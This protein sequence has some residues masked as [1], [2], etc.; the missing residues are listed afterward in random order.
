MYFFENIQI[1][2]CIPRIY[3]CIWICTFSNK[4]CMRYVCTLVCLFWAYYL[5]TSIYILHIYAYVYSQ[6][7]V[8]IFSV[9][10]SE[11]C[12]YYY[13]SRNN[14]VVLFGTLK[15]HDMFCCVYVKH[16]F[17]MYI[18]VKYVR[19][20]SHSLCIIYSLICMFSIRSAC[21]Y[22]IHVCV[23]VCVRACVCVCRYVCVCVY[24]SACKYMLYMCS[25]MYIPKKQYVICVM[26][27][28]MYVRK[29]LYMTYLNLYILVV[30][31]S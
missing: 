10:C 17:C 11:D 5:S 4:M 22:M 30:C 7:Y 27:I 23:C 21:I 24:V 14:V 13:S 9:Y 31:V 1:Y 26:C 6:L 20:Y 12:F 3:I 28:H 16:T 29:K 19:V 2:I 8:C 25:H 18:H 15:V